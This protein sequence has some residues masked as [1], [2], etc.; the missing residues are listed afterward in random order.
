[1][2]SGSYGRLISMNCL[3]ISLRQTP[4][5]PFA[6]IRPSELGVSI[7]YADESH[8]QAISQYLSLLGGRIFSFTPI[9]KH[10]AEGTREIRELKIRPSD[11]CYFPTIARKLTFHPANTEKFIFQPAEVP[12]SAMHGARLLADASWRCNLLEVADLPIPECRCVCGASY[13]VVTH[14]CPDC[15]GENPLG[16][17]LQAFG[18]DLSERFCAD[19]PAELEAG[20]FSSPELQSILSALQH[21]IDVATSEPRLPEDE[22]DE[23]GRAKALL[24]YYKELFIVPEVDKKT[25][26]ALAHL[27]EKKY[28]ALV[29]ACAKKSHHIRQSWSMSS[30]GAWGP[31][32]SFQAQVLG[33]F[34]EW[35]QQPVLHARDGF[36]K[37][38]RAAAL[39]RPIEKPL[40]S[41][42][43][44][45]GWG[46]FWHGIA[47]PALTGLA[48]YNTFGV[49]LA[50]KM[51]LGYFKG[52]K[53][54]QRY[55]AFASGVGDAVSAAQT[56]LADAEQATNK[57]ES[58][59]SRVE[60]GLGKHLQNLLYADYA[61]STPEQQKNLVIGF[62]TGLGLDASG[63]DA[64]KPRGI[65][66]ASTP[67][68]LPVDDGLSKSSP[69]PAKTGNIALVFIILFLVLAVGFLLLLALVH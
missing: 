46:D 40:R 37:L 69:S 61:Q 66:P 36:L 39:Y 30:L 59:F 18:T 32:E 26:S 34:S 16:W 48:A 15:D 41:V 49:S 56:A 47:K 64:L 52:K 9:S 2:E 22:S 60:V 8:L 45:T 28:A 6:W 17:A 11:E 44:R 13:P 31:D 27:R 55:Q 53:E 54:Q 3:S 23:K 4:G 67:P 21:F 1:V 25:F 35:W 29:I 19:L 12:E 62:L 7:K 38:F 63:I 65:K 42:V 14:F 50:L 24:N 58:L 68:P 10:N 51:G 57:E 5:E 20:S 43:E 33:Y